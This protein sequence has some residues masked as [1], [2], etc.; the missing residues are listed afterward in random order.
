MDANTKMTMTG[1]LVYLSASIPQ[2]NSENKYNNHFIVI[3]STK[4][5]QTNQ[6]NIYLLRTKIVSQFIRII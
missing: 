6:K 2:F 3:K 1:F 4:N 5:N